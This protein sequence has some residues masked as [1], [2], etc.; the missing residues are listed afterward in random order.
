MK[1]FLIALLLSCALSSP[2]LAGEI[3]MVDRVSPPTETRHGT[4]PIVPG[5][6]PSVGYAQQLSETA[7][8]LIQLMLGAGV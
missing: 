6:V 2:A 7:L 3:P 8:N 5:E 4:S 1:R